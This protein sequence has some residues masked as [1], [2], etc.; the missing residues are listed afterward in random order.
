MADAALSHGCPTACS[1]RTRASGPGMGMQVMVMVW[2][3]CDG[4][5]GGRGAQPV[6]VSAGLLCL[7]N[8]ALE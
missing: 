5:D 2:S 8:A 6:S 7:L 1:R 3:G 4:F